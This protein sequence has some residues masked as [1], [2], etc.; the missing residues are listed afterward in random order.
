MG[1]T[2]S[3]KYKDENNQWTKEARSKRIAMGG[4]RSR[5]E[6]TVYLGRC[7]RVK[8]QD[9]IEIEIV[10]V[11]RRGSLVVLFGPDE[12]EAHDIRNTKEGTTERMSKRAN[13]DWTEQRNQKDGITK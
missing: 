4:S 10:I 6:L 13:R 11:Q 2:L 7:G 9:A 12:S 1:S 3:V 8:R 5:I